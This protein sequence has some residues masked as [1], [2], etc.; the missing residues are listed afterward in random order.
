MPVGESAPVADERV[1]GAGRTEKSGDT[2]VPVRRVRRAL[3]PF[4][5]GAIA[6]AG[7]QRDP[8]GGFGGDWWAE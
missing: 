7:G 3:S 8:E 1:A 6:N 5:D 2:S 4:W